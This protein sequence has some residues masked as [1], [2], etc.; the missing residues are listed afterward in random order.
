M[1]QAAGS[2]Q[3]LLT[4][5]FS[6]PPS[7]SFLRDLAGP[8]FDPGRRTLEVVYCPPNLIPSRRKTGLL[9]TV[10]ALD[11]ADHSVGNPRMLTR[12]G[13]KAWHG[14]FPEFAKNASISVDLISRPAGRLL[15]GKISGILPFMKTIALVGAGH[16]H[17]EVIRLF[18]ERPLVDTRLVVVSD[19]DVAA[20]SGL[21]PAALSGQADPADMLIDLHKLCDDPN[22]ELIVD[23]LA[24][25]NGDAHTLTTEIGRTVE[26]SVASLD[27]GSRPQPKLAT[28]PGHV[29]LKPLQTFLDRLA[30]AS[31]DLGGDQLVRVAIVGGGA[32]GVELAYTVPDFVARHA[33]LKCEL[34][35]VEKHSHL[36]PSMDKSLGKNIGDELRGR[37][38]HVRANTVAVSHDGPN[39]TFSDGKTAEVDIVIEVTG[40]AGPD[41]LKNSDLPLTDNGFV[42]IDPTLQVISGLPVFAAGDCAT[43][44]E[45]P[46]PKAGV[47]AVRQAPVLWENLRSFLFVHELK[48][49][50]PQKSSLKLFNRGDGTAWGAWRGQLVGGKWVSAWKNQL[51]TSF[52]KKYQKV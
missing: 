38:V 8:V 21:L 29:A 7:K 28:H 44:V 32:G 4:I 34:W 43:C 12:F 19:S 23:P 11:W 33:G 48:D 14:A 26:F 31:K 45:S 51:D 15:C 24:S 50:K 37:G 17:L 39:V 1:K 27:I 49:F 18:R 6:V 47:Y 16:A 9:S 35:L 40:A 20:Y 36:L 10:C 3:R 46:W 2:Y 52:V 5:D 30:A 22:I 25:L 13:V 41:V 42:Q